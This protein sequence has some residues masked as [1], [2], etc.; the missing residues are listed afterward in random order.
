MSQHEAYV[1]GIGNFNLEGWKNMRI[2]WKTC[3]RVGVSAFLLYL[4]IYYWTGAAN[5]VMLAVSAAFPLVLGGVIAYVAN[6]LMSF[7]ERKIRCKKKLWQKARRPVCMLL[8]FITVVAALVLLIQLIIP[9]LISCFGV[10]IEA[11]PGAIES[12]YN[13]LEETFSISTW[14][15][16][17]LDTLPSGETDWESIINKLSGVLLN[18][19]GGAMNAVVAVTT[20]VVDGVITLFLSLIFAIYILTGKEKLASQFDRLFQ[21]VL[22]EARC[23]KVEAVL[24]ILN[25]CFHNYIVGQCLEAVILGS[26]CAVGMMLLR[27]PYALMIGALVGVLALI[28]IAG[29]YIG[30]AVGAVMIFS[31]SPIQAVIFLV[32]LVVLQQIEGNLIYPKTV[33]SSLGLPGI[34]VLASV[35]IG[36]SVMGVLGMIIFVPLTAAVYR[37]LGV[38]VRGEKLA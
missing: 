7:Y 31:V 6:I 37:L 38:Y 19:V 20:S 30:A 27:L 29:A 4:A 26:L 10:L 35:T 22:G 8:A 23:A 13:W 33:G 24:H 17:R 9:Q 18:G 14:M 25:D 21:R 3:L 36:G 5:L 15:E 12:L 1:P 34:W 2:E 16:G 28:P 32:F 11:L